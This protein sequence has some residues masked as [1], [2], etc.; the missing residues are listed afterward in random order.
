DEVA[1]LYH[2]WQIVSFDRAAVVLRLSVD[3]V[4]KAHKENQF[5][6]I[7]DG[8]AAVYYGM[9]NDKPILKEVLSVE[10]AQLIPQVKEELEKG[11]PFHSEEEKLRILEGIQAR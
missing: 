11:I 10:T 3:D 8:M 5:V 9:P 6:G 7:R 4:C 2:E 1:K